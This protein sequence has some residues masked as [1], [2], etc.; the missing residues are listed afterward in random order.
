MDTMAGFYGVVV[1]DSNG[2]FDEDIILL[3]APDELILDLIVFPD[4]C[5][6]GVGA[7]DISVNGGVLGYE[8]LWDSGQTTEDVFDLFGG[9]NN[10]I[11]IDS[12]ACQVMGSVFIED[13]EKPETEF[14]TF[15]DHR[16]FYDQLADPIIFIDMSPLGLF[17]SLKLNPDNLIIL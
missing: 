7:V 13:L 12:N 2:C 15:P 4:T 10:V 9:D 16:R 8:Y 14:N 3:L 5:S 6:K 1:Y 17:S 11:V